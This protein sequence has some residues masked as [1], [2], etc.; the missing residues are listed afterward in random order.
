M[1]QVLVGSRVSLPHQVL[2]D[3]GPRGHVLRQ[4]QVGVIGK[5]HG[6]T[7]QHAM[8]GYIDVQVPVDQDVLH[9]R[10]VE[11]VLDRAEARQLLGQR[12][13]DL[14]QLGLVDVV[15]AYINRNSDLIHHVDYS[16]NTL[17]HYAL[18]VKDSEA[19]LELVEY[20][21]DKGC[22]PAAANEAG[23]SPLDLAA[24]AELALLQAALS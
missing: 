18:E 12:L 21:L 2:V 7:L 13:G 24:A 16:G 1:P 8:P 15:K 20:L 5:A 19:R 23:E 10:V 4:Q 22:D 11:Q 9:R 3:A 6:N 14:M 17:L